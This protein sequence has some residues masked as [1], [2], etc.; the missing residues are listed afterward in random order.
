MKKIKNLVPLVIFGVA[1]L[2]LGV[3]AGYTDQQVEIDR[4]IEVIPSQDAVLERGANLFVDT[5]GVNKKIA[6]CWSG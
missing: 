6:A 5:D 3:Q 1:A 2:P 4:V